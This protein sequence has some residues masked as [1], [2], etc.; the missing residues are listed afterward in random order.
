MSWPALPYADWEPTKQTLH[1]YAQIVGKVRMALV[2]PR[3]HW[4]HVSLY[5]TAR[6]VSTGPMPAGDRTAEI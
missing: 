1:R 5:V 4:W 2:P 3:N 6:G